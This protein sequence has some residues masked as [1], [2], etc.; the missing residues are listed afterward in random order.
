MTRWFVQVEARFASV[1]PEEVEDAVAE[2]LERDGLLFDRDNGVQG[3]PG[4]I[5]CATL[6]IEAED[7]EAAAKRGWGVYGEALDA[8]GAAGYSHERT[9]T[10]PM[11]EVERR[12]AE[13]GVSRVFRLTDGLLVGVDSCRRLFA[14]LPKCCDPFARR[15]QI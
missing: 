12:F 2:R 8:A 13:N 1:W 7:A 10:E 4:P 9:V 11:A 15:C 5:L 6:V 14:I 3:D